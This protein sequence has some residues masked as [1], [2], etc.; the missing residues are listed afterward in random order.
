MGEKSRYG[1]VSLPQ[2]LIDRVEK[3]VTNNPKAGFT[4]VT[5]F[6]KYATREVLDRYE[7]KG[8]RRA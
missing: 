4:S 6:V 7:Q 2:S 5:D 3:Y 8:R 1:K